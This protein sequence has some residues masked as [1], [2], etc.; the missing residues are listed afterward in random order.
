MRTGAINN[1]Y[2]A[3]KVCICMLQINMQFVSPAPPKTASKSAKNAKF[4][5]MFVSQSD[6]TRRDALEQIDSRNCAPPVCEMT[7]N[8]IAWRAGQPWGCGSSERL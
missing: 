6:Q 2:V 3:T 7:A 5:E 1:A 4:E 8:S